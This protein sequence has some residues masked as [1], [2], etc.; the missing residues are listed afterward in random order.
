M[1]AYKIFS[2]FS[3]D[4]VSAVSLVIA[5][6]MPLFGVLF[7][8][9][10]AFNVLILYWTESAVIGFYYVLKKYKIGGINKVLNNSSFLFGYGIFMAGHLFFINF[11]FGEGGLSGEQYTKS[12]GVADH[13]IMIFPA[14]LSLFISHGISYYNNFIGKKEYLNF[15]NA[16]EAIINEQMAKPFKRI[17]IMQVALV[18]GGGLT[19]ILRFDIVLVLLIIFKIIADLKAQNKQYSLPKLVLGIGIIVA[20]IV[21]LGMADHTTNPP[22]QVSFSRNNGHCPGTPTVADID[23]NMYDTVQIG[24]QCWMKQN[25][26]VTK[27]PS[28]GAIT[29]YCYDNNPVICDTDGGLYAWTTMMNGSAGCNGTGASQPN[30]LPVVQGIC[31]DGWHAPSHYEWTMLEKNVGSNP[32]YFLYNESTIGW[33]GTD[34]GTNL[35]AGGSSGFEAI[36]AGK[37]FANMNETSHRGI[38]AFFWSSTEHKSIYG[39]LVWF[40]F[41]LSNYPPDTKVFRNSDSKNDG[42]SVRCIKD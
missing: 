15:K 7:W 38:E 2:F 1:S 41:L 39:D 37:Y 36:P 10:S 5:N 9:W 19:L 35:K 8:D 4:D 28:G 30:C 21:L 32:E 40:R 20:P 34:E 23:G 6:L 16:S 33:R 27:N 13:M 12:V 24:T 31:P 14:F 17:M 3:K 42:H 26:K 18:F 11:L 29:R 25:L 22:P